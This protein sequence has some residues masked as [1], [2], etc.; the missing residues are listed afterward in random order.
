[1]NQINNPMYNQ[2]Y[3][4][5]KNQAYNQMYNQSYIPTYNQ[6]YNQ[7]YTQTYNQMNNQMNNAHYLNIWNSF[8]NMN[9]HYQS[10]MQQVWIQK[11][12]SDYLKYC[13]IYNKNQNDIQ[14]FD[15][16]YRDCINVKLREVIP[17]TDKQTYLQQSQQNGPNLMNITFKTNSGVNVNLTV[18]GN[19]TV[20]ELL[21]RYLD[22]LNIPYHHLI[23]DLI[24]LF[25][26][27][28]IDPFSKGIISE[29]FRNNIFITV[30]DQGG[31]I[32]A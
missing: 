22:K 20:N 27:S 8:Q 32:G 26:G 28:S 30:L 12:Y 6:S 19:I 24:F 23:K 3:T 18:P 1:M 14:S 9:L 7:S 10:Q 16:Y 5:M 21:K 11:L 15:S 25:N 29:L 13:Q 2:F 17:R 31:I 4:Q